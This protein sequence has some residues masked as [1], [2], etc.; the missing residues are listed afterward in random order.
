MFN[1]TQDETARLRYRETQQKSMREHIGGFFVTPEAL[2]A[3]NHATAEPIGDNPCAY[4]RKE[5]ETDI[6]YRELTGKTFVPAVDLETFNYGRALGVPANSEL[7]AQYAHLER[8]A[9]IYADLAT[10]FSRLA[11]SQEMALRDVRNCETVLDQRATMALAV[12]TWTD[13]DSVA[14]VE[15]KVD[16]ETVK[17]FRYGRYAMSARRT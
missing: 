17:F 14:S 15:A 5:S 11:W 7:A 6:L 9:R 8:H 12:K 16:L 10:Q 4:A 2:I 3:R 1:L 13:A